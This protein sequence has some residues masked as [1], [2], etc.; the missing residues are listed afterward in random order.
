MEANKASIIVRSVLMGIGITTIYLM[1]GLALD[2]G[3][4]QL[5]SQFVIADCSED[6][7]FRYFSIFFAV[8]A[9]FGL[10]GGIRSGIR[11]YHRLSGNQ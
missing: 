11:L 8:A 1:I 3:L 5:Y 9:V 10:M 7:Y 2:Y 6:C 4:T